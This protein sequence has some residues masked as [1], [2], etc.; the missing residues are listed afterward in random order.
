VTAEQSSALELFIQSGRHDPDIVFG[1]H[2]WLQRWRTTRSTAEMTTPSPPR[3]AG[4]SPSATPSS[5]TRSTVLIRQERRTRL[6]QP[7]AQRPTQPRC[8]ICRSV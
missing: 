3:E 1:R 2:R 7:A 8:E 6:D 5:R 4:R